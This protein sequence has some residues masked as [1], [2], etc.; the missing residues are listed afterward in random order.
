MAQN[1]QNKPK[2]D[3]KASILATADYISD[4]KAQKSYPQLVHFFWKKI[5]LKFPG[6]I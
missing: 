6:I 2:N 3:K 4:L 5:Q 1:D